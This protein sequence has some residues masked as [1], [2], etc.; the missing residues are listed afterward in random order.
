MTQS[1]TQDPSKPLKT[2]EKTPKE[3]LD[4]VFEIASSAFP[5]D[6]ATL[7]KGML[8]ALDAHYYQLMLSLVEQ[9]KYQC[10]PENC[11]DDLS[12]ERQKGI[13]ELATELE[14]KLSEHFKGEGEL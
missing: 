4:D 2:V 7:R 6:Y 1:N 9:A 5:E 13:N 3:I 14:A 10:Y 8:K 12:E 11:W